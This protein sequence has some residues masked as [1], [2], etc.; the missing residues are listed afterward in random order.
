MDN[1]QQNSPERENKPKRNSMSAYVPVHRRTVDNNNGERWLPDAVDEAVSRRNSVSKYRSS[2]I[3]VEASLSSSKRSSIQSR[4]PNSNRFS[5]NSF[6]TDDDLDYDKKDYSEYDTECPQEDWESILRQYDRYG[7]FDDDKTNPRKSKRASR[8]L[9]SYLDTTV[10]VPPPEEP[11]TILDCHDFP[12]SFQTHHLHDIFR[13]YEAMRG[14]YKIKWLS[15]TRALI[16]FEHPATAKKAYIDN[17]T[18]ALAKIRPYDG[19]TDFLRDRKP[20]VNSRSV[21]MDLKRHS[22]NNMPGGR[23]NRNSMRVEE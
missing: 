1:K 23:S 13:N 7:S 10:H 21:S 9:E 3:M 5:R 19:P 14:G 2:D 20:V 17:V 16:I 22:F 18:N 12:P 11:T 4:R 6:M 15:D 8:L